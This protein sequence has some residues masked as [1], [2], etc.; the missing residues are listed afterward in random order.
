MKRV[1]ARLMVPT[2]LAGVL[3]I[4]P[5]AAVASPA[6][7]AWGS[8]TISAIASN[9]GSFTGHRSSQYCS[10]TGIYTH[11]QVVEAHR[12]TWEL[13]GNCITWSSVQS[14]PACDQIGG[15]LKY[16][17]GPWDYSVNVRQTTPLEGKFKT[18]LYASVDTT[19]GLFSSEKDSNSVYNPG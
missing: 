1:V 16:C 19:D 7:A 8:C 5:F 18:K 9:V 17:P 2:M 10:G 4:G 15:T 14:W 3:M 6:S 13:F 12:C 11:H